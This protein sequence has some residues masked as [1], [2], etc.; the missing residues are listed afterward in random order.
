MIDELLLAN[1]L[2][3]LLESFDLYTREPDAKY[4]TV[5]RFRDI[6]VPAIIE[7]SK[8]KDSD[9]FMA[10]ICFDYINDYCDHKSCKNCVLLEKKGYCVKEER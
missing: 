8:V 5:Q 10:L 1:N 2:V 6:I 7:K 3:K 9:D 4:V